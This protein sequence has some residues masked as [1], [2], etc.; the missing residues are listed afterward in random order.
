[1]TGDDVTIEVRDLSVRFPPAG[2]SG[3]DSRAVRGI[4]LTLRR[5]EVHALVGESGSGKSVTARSILRL[6]GEE[7]GAEISGSVRLGGIDLYSLEEKKLRAVRGSEIAMIFQEPSR[8]L[9]PSMRIGEQIA[10]A[11]QAH[12]KGPRGETVRRV[13]ELLGEVGLPARVR[14]QYAHQLS[15]GMAQRAMIAMAVSCEPAF[16]IADEPTTSLDVTIQKQILDLLAHL[17]ADRRMGMLFISHDLAVVQSIAQRI[18]VMY[19]GRIVE[20]GTAED[21]LGRPLHPYTRAL[22]GA[23]P[24]A[25]RR[26]SPLTLIPGKVPDSRNIPT[27]C[28]FHPRC[29]VAEEICSRLVPENREYGGQSSHRGECHLI[30]DGRAVS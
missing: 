9:N 26:G 12:E 4:S 22:I 14:R 3:A 19:A 30:P 29:P 27:G 23:V 7:T 25:G 8:Y 21:V 6:E 17:Q 10:E 18:S 2:K 13:K 24:S 28:P 5:G 11:I 16:L 20:A 1:M 15:G